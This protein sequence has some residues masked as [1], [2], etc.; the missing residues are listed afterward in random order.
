M[1]ADTYSEFAELGWNIISANKRPVTSSVERYKFLV[2]KLKANSCYWGIN[3][4]VGAAL[5]VQA[6]LQELIQA[7]DRVLSI[8][9]VFSGSL[10]YLLTKFD[11][12]QS[13]TELVR[14]ACEAGITEPDPREDL[15][16]TDVQRKLLILSRI[17]GY[18]INLEDI[19]VDPLLPNDLLAGSLADFWQRSEQIDQFMQ[20]AFENAQRKNNKLAYLAQVRFIDKI[21][22]GKVKLESLPVNNAMTQLTPTDNAF[23]LVTDFY[24]KNPLII[25]G[26]GAG[27]EV[28]ATAVN[29]DLNKY[30][31]QIAVAAAL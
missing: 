31:T 11:G 3:A 7:G 8:S 23:E 24:N 10:S 19:D 22:Q 16:G 30:I 18:I 9:G 15:S 5:P 6:S 27:S 21:A 12:K 20:N 29:I 28:T 25:R 17:A 4:T 1:V 26:P 13:F 14:Q 2:N